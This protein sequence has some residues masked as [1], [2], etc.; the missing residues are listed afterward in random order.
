MRHH[1]TASSLSARA[2]AV[3]DHRALLIYTKLA[4]P[5]T[6]LT[7]KGRSEQAV[8]ETRD[9]GCYHCNERVSD[10]QDINFEEVACPW[11][12]L[13]CDEG[14]VSVKTLLRGVVA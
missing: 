12:T 2:A 7:S 6:V 8:F 11:R 5:D 4:I 14:V 9:S 10:C 1:P 3:T 13:D